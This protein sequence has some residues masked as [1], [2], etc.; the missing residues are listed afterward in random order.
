MTASSYYPGGSDFDYPF[1][2]RLHG[3]RGD[4]W[5]AETRNGINDWLQVDFEK[6]FAVCGVA[7]QGAISSAWVT[8]FK[9]GFSSD[10]NTWRTYKYDNGSEVVRCRI[11]YVIVAREKCREY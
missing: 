7:T 2:G 1:Y 4:G 11:F 5:C 3:S 8:V 10:G 6:A 9:L